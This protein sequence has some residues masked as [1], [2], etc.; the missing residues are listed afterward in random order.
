MLPLSG[1]LF[2]TFFYLIDAVSYETELEPDLEMAPECAAVQCDAP[3][4]YEAARDPRA[5]L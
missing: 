5:G 4:P 3:P 1:A 2:V